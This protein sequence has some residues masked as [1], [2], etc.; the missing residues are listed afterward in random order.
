MPAV[1]EVVAARAP[2]TLCGPLAAVVRGGDGQLA[3]VGVEARHVLRDW[4]GPGGVAGHAEWRS[5]AARLPGPHGA[6]RGMCSIANTFYS[7][8]HSEYSALAQSRAIHPACP[9]KTYLYSASARSAA[10]L[11]TISLGSFSGSP[12]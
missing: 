2:L 7:L 6:G 12:G 8:M 4:R 5:A 10:R 3:G 9:V 11:S 1:S